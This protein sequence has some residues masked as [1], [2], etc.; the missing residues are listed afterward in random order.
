[1]IMVK[2]IYYDILDEIGTPKT[3]TWW[4]L[5][6]IFPSLKCTYLKH[7]WELIESGNVIK[8]GV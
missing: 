7:L 1:M 4:N 8:K 6:V 2:S 5:N 3:T